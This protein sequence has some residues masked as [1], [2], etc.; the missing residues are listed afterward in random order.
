MQACDGGGSGAV[1]TYGKLPAGP[2]GGCKWGRQ[3]MNTQGVAQTCS[4][5]IG[6]SESTFSISVSNVASYNFSDYYVMVMVCGFSLYRY[7]QPIFN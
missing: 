5:M 1:L 4:G 6:M 2:A 7:M 3:G